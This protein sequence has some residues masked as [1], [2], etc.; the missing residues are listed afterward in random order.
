[1]ETCQKIPYGIASYKTIR[2]ENYYY[3]DKTRFLPLLEDTGKFLFLIRPRRFGKSSWLTVLESYYDIARQEEWDLLFK[4]T[5]I[6]EHPTRE[7]HAYLILKVNFS[8]VDPR[9]E[10]VETSFHKHAKTCFHFFGEKYGAWL[11]EDYFELIRDYHTAHEKLEFTAAYIGSLGRKLYVLIDEYDNFANT[12]LTTA[13]TQA[14]HNLTHGAGFFRFFFNVLKGATDQVESGVGRMFITGVSPVTMDDVTSGFNIGRN[15]NLHP[16]FAELLGFTNAD[17]VQILEYYRTHSD[18]TFPESPEMLE[19][20]REWYDGYRFAA[21][22]SETLFNPDMVF[23]FLKNFLEL[24]HPPDAMIDR[25]IRVDYGK[26]RHLVV[27]NKQLNGNFNRL[28]QIVE[29]GGIASTV[30]DSFPVESLIQPENFVSLLFYFGLLSYADPSYLRIPNQTVQQLMYSYLREGYRDMEVFQIDL[31]HF[32]NLMRQMAYQGDWEPV[33]GFLAAEVDRQTSIQDYLS[34]EKV[35]Q[36]FLLAYL[37]VTDYYLTR[38]EDEMGK[39]FVDLYLEPFWQKYPEV[40]RGYLIELKYVPR[41]EWSEVRGQQE[42]AAAQT[43]LRQY[44]SDPRT[45]HSQSVTC[46]ALVFCG[47]ELKIAQAV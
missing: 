36:T 31:L 6:Y 10:N 40:R 30:V 17:V 43:Q 8:Q 7:K 20:L 19:L 16:H 15:M 12:I 24:E 9:A 25:N 29:T 35:I 38:T 33:F 45:T 28:E 23:Y 14:Y 27:L 44:R 39:G 37:N 22:T 3:I 11:G 41:S 21:D 18:V 34:G 13:G 42:L 4:D 26:L 46:A 47:W 32:A 2:Q 1:M 5:F